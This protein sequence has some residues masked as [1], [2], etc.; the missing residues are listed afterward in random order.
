MPSIRLTIGLV[1]DQPKINRTKLSHRAQNTNSKQHGQSKDGS[2]LASPG[3]LFTL[4][5]SQTN[6][7]HRRKTS[8]TSPKHSK[9]GLGP[10]SPGLLLAAAVH[11]CS[12]WPDARL[13]GDLG[14]E[15]LIEEN[16][17]CENLTEE[18]IG[19]ENL[20]RRKC[21]TFI[22]FPSQ[23]RKSRRFICYKHSVAGRYRLWE[24]HRRKWKIF[25]C[26]QTLQ[27]R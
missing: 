22:C 8:N 12:Y 24:C 10:A 27:L 1:N 19:C 16:L 7:E 11:R 17:G 9:V 20:G 23:G 13:V 25:L 26:F 6:T 3:I 5:L 4:W 2:V 18:N 21:C 15:N 14:C